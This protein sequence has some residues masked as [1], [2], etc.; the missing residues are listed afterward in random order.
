MLLYSG[1]DNNFMPLIIVKAQV[2]QLV[3][4]ISKEKGLEVDNVTSDYLPALDRKVR[5]LVEESV[6]RAKENGRRTL[7]A[8]DV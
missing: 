5:K 4:Q 1:K 2:A 6:A 7:M 3:K 8:R